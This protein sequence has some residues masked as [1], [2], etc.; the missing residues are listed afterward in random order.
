MNQLSAIRGKITTVNSGLFLEY[1]YRM[2]Y[3]EFANRLKVL[4][5][6]SD[7]PKTQYKFADWLGL[8]KSFVSELLR[9]EKLPSMDT[10]IKISNKLGSA[11]PFIQLFTVG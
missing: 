2:E 8:S 11:F 6:E 7:A 10:A 5:L 1:S 9:G 3:K 4:Q